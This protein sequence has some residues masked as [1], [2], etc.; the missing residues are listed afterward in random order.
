MPSGYG[1]AVDA[2]GSGFKPGVRA[3]QSGYEPYVVSYKI[4]KAY[5]AGPK[6][7]VGATVDILET[8][9]SVSTPPPA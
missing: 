2:G 7:R 8:L 6:F 3:T 1:A 4:L 5:K 9:P